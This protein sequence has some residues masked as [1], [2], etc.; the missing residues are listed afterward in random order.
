M[1]IL[2]PSGV[3]GILAGLLLA[4][5]TAAAT[6]VSTTSAGA[7]PTRYPLTIGNCG[8]S[9][10]FTR[11]PSRVVSLGQANT[12]ILYALGLADKVVGTAVWFGPVPPE[13]AVANAGIKRL[14]DNDP[15]FEAVVG[16]DPD[17][18]SAQYEWHVGPRGSVGKREQ[19]TSLGIPTYV[20][21]ADCTAKDNSGG[22]DGVRVQPITME[23]VYQEIR[24]MAAVFD[25]AERGEALVAELQ[26]R[27]KAAVAA[28]A[29][30]LPGT[31][32]GR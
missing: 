22:G 29:G 16:Q 5:A 13:Y 15:S 20:A 18:V 28:I 14:A 2:R 12:E 26:A 30:T 8:T 24:D 4:L 9:L 10:T 3:P 27:E 17:L 7:A 31:Y 25:V 21:P 11:A 1:P 32:P 23:P 6:A 19:F